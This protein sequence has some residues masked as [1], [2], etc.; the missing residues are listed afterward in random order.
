M[1]FIYTCTINIGGP[2]VPE[3]TALLEAL[4]VIASDSQMI[5]RKSF[6]KMWSVPDDDAEVTTS[7]NCDKVYFK[8]APIT[9]SFRFEI[10]TV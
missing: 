10:I 1:P 8:L 4:S 9:V 6:S 5:L 7:C 3:S 2:K